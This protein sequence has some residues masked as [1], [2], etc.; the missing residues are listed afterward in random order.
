VGRALRGRPRGTCLDLPTLGGE[1]GPDHPPPGSIVPTN[2]ARICDPFVATVELLLHG[3]PARPRA[4]DGVTHPDVRLDVAT[5]VARAVDLD[6]DE[7][8]FDDVAPGAGEGHA[9]PLLPLGDGSL[10]DQRPR[11]DAENFGAEPLV[12][13][14]PGVEK[15]TVGAAPG[16]V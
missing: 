10:H 3:R 4:S 12:D 2:F 5:G 11:T 8:T 7:R 1:G 15:L 16:Q 9:R 13:A 14:E 6:G